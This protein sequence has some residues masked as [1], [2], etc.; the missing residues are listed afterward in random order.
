MN[1]LAMSYKNLLEY[2]LAEELYSKILSTNDKYINDDQINQANHDSSNDCT[3]CSKGKYRTSNS[4]SACQDC[5]SGKYLSDDA[6]NQNYHDEASDCSVCSSSRYAVGNGNH[7]C[8][9]CPAGK[10]IYDSSTVNN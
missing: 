9:W 7:E 5:P 2:D 3:I 8:T 1:N 4:N 6:S 10:Q